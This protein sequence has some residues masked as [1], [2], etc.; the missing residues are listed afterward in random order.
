LLLLL[1]LSLS[2]SAPYYFITLKAAINEANGL[3]KI[4]K[5]LAEEKEELVYRCYLGLGQYHIIINEVKSTAAVGQNAIKLLATYLQDP[6]SAEIVTLQLQ[7]WLGD[8]ALC[9]NKTLQT[10]AALICL[11]EDSAKE[12]CKAIKTGANMEQWALLVQMYLK[13][14]RADLAQK[15]L[16]QMKSQDED[17]PLTML[18]NCWVNMTVGGAKC[19]EASYA[20]EE[21]IDKYG[22]TS[23]LLNGLAVSKMHQGYFEEAEANLNEALTKSPNDPDTLANLITV[24]HHL[25]K[26]DDIIGRLLSQLQM[27]APQHPLLTTVTNFNS[28]FDRVAV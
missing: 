9:S 22:A 26:G 1:S 2:L 3:K 6:S 20:Y 25:K 10:I 27:K 19:Q 4:P 17:N 16:A 12:A 15:Q 7:E 23:M 21:L 14:D 24:S 8:A 28:A 11:N 5:A 18:A 13:I